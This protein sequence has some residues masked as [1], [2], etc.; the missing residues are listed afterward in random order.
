MDHN[1]LFEQSIPMSYG[2]QPT[3][4]HPYSSW[5]WFDQQAHVPP[6]FRPQYV[7]Y[8]APRHPKRS[9]SC[10]DC[11]GN[12]TS[13]ENIAPNFGAETLKFRNNI[14]L[15]RKRERMQHFDFV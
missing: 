9:S 3:S 7:E 1:P 4:F 2:P 11:V 6:Y 14:C 13:L 10:K 5:E 15:H 8:A 12:L